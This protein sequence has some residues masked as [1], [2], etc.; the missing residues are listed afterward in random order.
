M[1]VPLV[2]NKFKVVYSDKLLLKYRERK[3]NG[4]DENGLPDDSLSKK[5]EGIFTNWTGDSRVSRLYLGRYLDVYS[6][7]GNLADS[8]DDGRVVLTAD[9]FGVPKK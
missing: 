2:G 4:F 8:Y 6:S 7:S 1:F 9:E 3:F 5:G